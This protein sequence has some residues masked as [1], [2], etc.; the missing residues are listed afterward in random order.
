MPARS[1][2]LGVGAYEFRRAG[3]VA[4]VHDFVAVDRD[5]LHKRPVVIGGV[6]FAARQNGVGRFGVVCSDA[7]R[8][9]RQDERDGRRSQ[10]RASGSDG[11]LRDAPRCARRLFQHHIVHRLC[12]R[13]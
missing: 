3:G 2:C 4:G 13:R 1:I 6:D 8:R 9:G 5:R 10:P 12:V 11:L 7:A